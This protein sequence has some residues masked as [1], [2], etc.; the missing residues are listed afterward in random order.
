MS[1]TAGQRVY[2]YQPPTPHQIKAAHTLIQKYE[3]EVREYAARMKELQGYLNESTDAA[4]K[5][6]FQVMINDLFSE[7]EERRKLLDEQKNLIAPIRLLP[8]E[9]LILIFEHH[10][11][12]ND[13]SLWTILAVCRSWRYVGIG[14][15]RI[16]N[17]LEVDLGH[18]AI[19]NPK[20]KNNQSASPD[21]IL[22]S[23]LDMLE[24]VLLRSGVIPIHVTLSLGSDPIDL[25]MLQLLC[26][27]VGSRIK[28][29][30]LKVPTFQPTSFLQAWNNLN[31]SFPNLE[32]FVLASPVSSWTRDILTTV[33]TTSTKLR[34]LSFDHPCHIQEDI[35]PLSP[36]LRRIR[37]L[38]LVGHYA[39]P[40][41]ARLMWHKLIQINTLSLAHLYDSSPFANK[42]ESHFGQLEML[43]ILQVSLNGL[44]SSPVKLRSLKHIHIDTITHQDDTAN[45]ASCSIELSQV[46]HF[47]LKNKNYAPLLWFAL[48]SLVS[49]ELYGN[50]FN[51]T[52]SNDEIDAM[53]NLD[54]AGRVPCPSAILHIETKANDGY[55]LSALSFMDHI[56]HLYL[57]Y[58]T[59]SSVGTKLMA[60]LANPP[61]KRIAQNPEALKSWQAPKLPSLQTLT[62]ICKKVTNNEKNQCLGLLERIREAR[63]GTASEMKTLRLSMQSIPGKCSLNQA[64]EI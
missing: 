38:R 6:E 11:H 18:T 17:K 24:I 20:G 64:R 23:N 12:C 44:A 29:F 46:T 21:G 41:A 57:Y 51:K 1:S 4:V 22:C 35:G 10:V 45:L 34:S 43:N 33:C 56:Q 55:I 14:T 19:L 52:Q 62:I 2:H 42:V 28:T 31:P 40:D 58:D 63:L 8:A 54:T 36:A 5:Q 32:A 47:T 9:L 59:P 16:W 13:Q 3:S 26:I 27:Q 49:L 53:W 25:A 30:R 15:P 48:P 7:M 39:Y 60:A 37:H 61:K 50:Q